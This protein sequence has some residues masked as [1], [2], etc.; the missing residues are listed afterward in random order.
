MHCF[1]KPLKNADMKMDLPKRKLLLFLDLI[2]VRCPDCGPPIRITI[3]RNKHTNY[4][5]HSCVNE[6]QSFFLIKDT[7]ASA[8]AS[9]PGGRIPIADAQAKAE[10]S[11]AIL[12]VSLE[13]NGFAMIGSFASF[14][15]KY[16]RDTQRRYGNQQWA[17]FTIPYP[18]S[19][20][21]ALYIELCAAKV[22]Q[23]GTLV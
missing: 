7:T 5:R 20:F 14:M 3:V 17:T 4:I 1:R 10:A 23:G 22:R 15:E 6:L 18:A 19:A 12:K 11:V 2:G 9:K 21:N 13:G 16:V 8:T